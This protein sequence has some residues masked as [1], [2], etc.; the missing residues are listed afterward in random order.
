MDL[1]KQHTK[2]SEFKP[3]HLGFAPEL[4]QERIPTLVARRKSHKLFGDEEKV[5]SLTLN[6]RPLIEVTLRLRSGL[7]KRRFANASFIL[8]G[9][10][11][12]FVRISKSLSFH[13]GLEKVLG[14]K[15]LD[16]EILKVLEVGK[17]HSLIDIS[18]KIS[19]SEEVVRKS[20]KSLEEGRLVR[21][22]KIGRTKLYHRLIDLP[23]ME[24]D[25]DDYFLEIP[26]LSFSDAGLLQSKVSEEQV[27][28]LVRGM[29]RDG[30]VERFRLFYYPL[31]RVRLSLKGKS[32]D[33]YLDGR[34][35][36]A[37]EF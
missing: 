36:K 23:R 31:Y 19:A 28:D 7:I 21:S 35:G 6:Y 32:R 13:Q 17:D 3:I 22:D 30:D 27:R 18:S 8:D 10:T 20:I 15:P 2:T 4:S 34:T 24:L 37:V 25:R 5:V 9:I 33:M 14:L 26:E 11:G 1:H 16:L 12:K 29:W